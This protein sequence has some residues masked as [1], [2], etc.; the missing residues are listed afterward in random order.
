MTKTVDPDL[1]SN[2]P[3]C[4]YQIDPSNLLAMVRATQLLPRLLVAD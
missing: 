4:C 1:E 2:S 3:C